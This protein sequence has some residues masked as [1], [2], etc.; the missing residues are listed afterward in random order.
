MTDHKTWELPQEDRDTLRAALLAYKA[1]GVENPQIPLNADID[2]DGV[3]DAWALDENG[4]VVLVPQVQLGETVY[5]SEG[6][7]VGAGE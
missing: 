5:A 1:D 3:V 2:G 6:A 7:D 4:D